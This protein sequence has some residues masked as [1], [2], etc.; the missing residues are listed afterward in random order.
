MVRT[1]VYCLSIRYRIRSFI[2]AR[3]PA[4]LAIFDIEVCLNESRYSVD[5]RECR[6][7]YEGHLY[8]ID[9]QGRRQSGKVLLVGMKTQ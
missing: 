5:G 8:E 9:I 7:V 1:K 3:E 4:L 2:E 6:G